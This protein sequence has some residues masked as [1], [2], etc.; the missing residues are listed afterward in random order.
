MR[1]SL[2]ELTRYL[3]L[4]DALV[5]SV[6]STT[7][8]LNVLCVGSLAFARELWPSVTIIARS[9]ETARKEILVVV[10]LDVYRCTVRKQI[11]IDIAARTYCI[12]MTTRKK[13][14]L[15]FDCDELIS[16]PPTRV[17]VLWK[18]NQP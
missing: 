16:H 13:L 18:P 4:L 9:L 11:D 15:T 1:S 2:S 6:I 7:V 10:V 14:A 3:F 12:N 8:W 5:I 17:S